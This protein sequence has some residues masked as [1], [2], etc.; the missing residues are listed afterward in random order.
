M[1]VRA[2][3]AD[4]RLMCWDSILSEKGLVQLGEAAPLQTGHAQGNV[5]LIYFDVREE[6]VNGSVDDPLGRELKRPIDAQ[7]IGVGDCAFVDC[8]D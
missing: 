6:K 4:S 5:P 8:V 7:G 1:W 3:S 2:V